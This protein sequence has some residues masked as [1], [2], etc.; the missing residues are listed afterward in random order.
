[1]VKILACK[2]TD[3]LLVGAWVIGSN[4][5]EMIG[6]AVL[7]FEYGASSKDVARKRHTHLTLSESF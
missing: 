1:M 2:K 5:G 3:K 6:E 7:A 4:A